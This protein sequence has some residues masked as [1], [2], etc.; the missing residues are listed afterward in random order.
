MNTLVDDPKP[1]DFF[2]FAL[3]PRP[4]PGLRAFDEMEWPIFFGRER[5]VDAVVTQ[6]VSQHLAVVHGDSGSGKSS[7]IRAGVLPRL[8]QEQARGGLRWRTVASMPRGGPLRNLARALAALDGRSDDAEWVL[9][10]RRALNQGRRAPAVLAELLRSSA[11]DCVCIL[12]D[13]FEE[14]FEH[15]R[16]QGPGEARL[17]TDVLVAVAESPPAGLYV[18][19]TMRSEYLGACARFP[20]LAEAVNAH[21]YLLPPMAVPDLLRA[22]REPALLYGGEVDLALAE[23]LAADATG[24]DGLP[25]VQ[26]GLMLMQR[27]HAPLSGDL[28]PQ[29]HWR[30]SLAHYP[31]GG[32]AAQLSRHAD[33]VAQHAQALAPAR[34]RL[35]EDL[36]RALSSINAEGLAVRRPQLL[37]MLAATL[38]V[39][40]S[41]LVQVID[42]FRA[43]GVTLLLPREGR[44]LVQDDWIDISHEALIRSWK[45]LADPQEGWLASEFRNGLVWRAL[46]VQAESFERDRDNVLSPATTEERVSWLKRRNPTW[47]ERYGGGWDRVQ[48]LVL[49]SLNRQQEIASL[50]ERELAARQAEAESKR[51]AEA[52]AL[53]QAA[54][55]KARRLR[56]RAWVLASALMATALVAWAAFD[57]SNKQDLLVRAG[58][59]NQRDPQLSLRLSIEA[60]RHGV[61]FDL[62]GDSTGAEQA[63]RGAIRADDI[64][65]EVAGY[66]PALILTSALSPDGKI[67]VTGDVAG[68]VTFWDVDSGGRG[69]KNTSSLAS[70]FEHVGPVNALAYSRSG[71]WLASGGGDGRVVV[72]DL[73]NGKPV[74]VLT[75]HA[76]NVS[77]LAFSRDDRHLASAGESDG[78]I[79]IWDTVKGER[80]STLQGH[81]G[82]VKALVYGRDLDQLVSAGYDNR[83]IH[84]QAEAGKPRYSQV[85][86]SVNDIDLTDDGERMAVAGAEVSVWDL[87]T[88]ARIA[89]IRGH[90]AEVFHARFSGDRKRLITN[91]YDGTVRIWRLPREGDTAGQLL[92]ET[93]RYRAPARAWLLHGLSID[94]QGDLMASVAQY[95]DRNE[96]TVWRRAKGGERDAWIADEET[97]IRSLAFAPGSSEVFSTSDQGTVHHRRPTP[98][99]EA[100]PERITGWKPDAT[101]GAVVAGP[102]GSFAMA[103]DND[104]LVWLALSKAPLR[105]SG[106]T[107]L[108]TDLRFSADGNRLFTASRL[109]GSAIVWM[110][111]TGER[112]CEGIPADEEGKVASWEAISYAADNGLVATSDAHGTIRLHECREP[113]WAFVRQLSKDGGKHE[114]LVND[115]AFTRDARTLFSAGADKSIGVWDTGSG[116]LRQFLYGHQAEVRALAL[117]DGLLASAAAD[118]V[119]LWRIDGLALLPAFS[120]GTEGAQS[121]AFSADGKLLGAGSADGT[122]RV[123][124]LHS[125]DLPNL[126]QARTRRG[127]SQEECNEYGLG[128]WWRRCPKSRFDLL[129]S[130]KQAF[131]QMDFDKG[132]SIL[133]QVG[134]KQGDAEAAELETNARIEASV[135]WWLAARAE[136]I[137]ASI[138]ETDPRAADWAQL[139]SEVKKLAGAI[140]LDPE[141]RLR[142]VKAYNTIRSVARLAAEGDAPAVAAAY[143]RAQS[144]GWKLHESPHVL[145]ARLVAVEASRKA[146]FATAE[147][148]AGEIDVLKQRLRAGIASDPGLGQAH[149][150]LG[151]L[152]VLEKDEVA[153]EYHLP[154]AAKQLGGIE[155]LADLANLLLESGRV[156]AAAQWA[157]VALTADP[158]SDLAALVV[159]QVRAEQGNWDEA[160]REF[161]KV[162]PYHEQYALAT[163][164]AAAILFEH[165][166]DLRATRVRFERA[167]VLRPDDISI[168]SNYAEFMLATRQLEPAVKLAR[169]V[170]QHPGINASD[171]A[172]VRPAMAFVMLAAN[173]PVTLKTGTVAPATDA[174][175]A[176]ER[177]VK[178]QPELRTQDQWTFKGIRRELGKGWATDGA[179]AQRALMEVLDY[180]ESNGSRGSLIAMRALLA[181]RSKG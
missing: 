32:L 126:A 176:I 16:L 33:A 10:L 115:L 82:G 110:F 173:L 73:V 68:G 161:D 155:P 29:L 51:Q 87:D 88:R 154:R 23:R 20:G 86:S 53:A 56:T 146:F 28:D 130:A 181:S 1:E 125:N 11:E 100:G 151:L 143:S 124:A 14:L 120:T 167:V 157:M 166:N 135:L 48:A 64:Q 70:Q 119:R 5:M 180:V 37:S 162:S 19:V 67:L 34:E 52:Q 71:R 4:Y 96:V 74:H 43:D 168:L 12:I 141:A 148:P 31:E 122:V 153:A 152:A 3:P 127:W 129:V 44:P 149:W 69:L 13:Q 106:H 8:S 84:W 107:T 116:K 171:M 26:H 98:T 90:N 159:G 2:S 62:I 55:L 66:S 94:R 42:V 27:E 76:G 139:A 39:E 136:E 60:M 85:F 142:E 97:G 112:S 63:L 134:D 131:G 65:A 114:G 118:G 111:P 179:A 36:F 133:R 158:R 7:L 24:A 99:S 175:D 117:R 6:L 25:L 30:L 38:M 89:E 79:Q 170:L 140:R 21:Q 145:A 108:V 92:Q 95:K 163:N 113:H 41:E 40:G 109:D 81:M 156:P 18:A 9:V 47:A 177:F 50:R 45:A 123:Y 121:L 165:K 75:A 54:A 49:A 104:V 103:Q 105:L 169:R 80:L 78:L 101:V 59:Q 17:L 91:G 164:T 147:T 137:D 15:A 178:K 150:A 93:G 72:W 174:M 57:L 46:L 77:S 160:V 138:T 132:Q 83:V 58:G 128:H 35:V 61:I 144:L 172:S 102:G 22:I